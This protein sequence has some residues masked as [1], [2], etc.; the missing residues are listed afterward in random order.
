M[1]RERLHMAEETRK[2]VQEKQEEINRLNEELK[3]HQ[4]RRS[5]EAAAKEETSRFVLGNLCSSDLY[6]L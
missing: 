3:D 6:A 1:A 2:A 4:E 5:A